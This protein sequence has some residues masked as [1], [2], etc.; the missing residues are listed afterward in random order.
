MTLIFIACLFLP[1]IY[2]F[3]LTTHQPSSLLFRAITKKIKH[4][5]LIP[6]PVA[7]RYLQSLKNIMNQ[8]RNTDTSNQPA[9]KKMKSST[10]AVESYSSTK[11]TTPNK[12]G[13]IY[14]TIGPQCAGKTT[15]LKRLFGQSFHKNEDDIVVSSTGKSTTRKEEGGVDITID[16]QKLVYIPVATSYFLYNNNASSNTNNNNNNNNSSSNTSS[17]PSLNSTVYDK[18]IRERINDPSNAELSL[19]TQRLGGTLTANEFAARIQQQQGTNNGRRSNGSDSNTNATVQE[20]LI[21]AV[22]HTIQ[23]NESSK[24]G[25]EVNDVTSTLLPEKIDLFIVESIFQPRPMKLM[26][27][28]TSNNSNS[29][30]LQSSSSSETVSALDQSIHLLKSYATDNKLHS[31]TAPLSSGNTNTRPREFQN[32]LEAAKIS[33]RPVEFIVF[34]G[35]EACEMICQNV[36]RREYRAM[37]HEQVIKND[38]DAKGKDSTALLCLP[39]VNRRTLFLRNINRFVETG[40]YIPSQAIDDAMVRVESML[41]NAAAEAN[42]R[43]SNSNEECMKTTSMEDAKFLLDCELAKLA[44][45]RLNANRTVSGGN[46]NNSNN[47]GGRRYESGR[48][49]NNNRNNYQSGR[50]GNNSRYQ[51]RPGRYGSGRGHYQGRGR[52]NYSERGGY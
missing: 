38:D 40:R 8:G 29:T 27:R 26:Q 19:V 16:D 31:T 43:V 51:H 52:N 10:S 15:I 41:A 47:N 9:N 32:A 1:F 42:K 6:I 48:C 5:S 20:D 23:L 30:K 35:N 37:P 45:Y 33:N 4:T 46:T 3:Q 39:K 21:N 36:S 12:K 2:G 44:G 50:G 49:N 24:S 22:E 28:L 14:I 13:T 34:G 11:T 18:T 25:G 17:F 7:G